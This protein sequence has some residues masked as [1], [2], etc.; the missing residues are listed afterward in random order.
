MKKKNVFLLSAGIAAGIG[1]ALSFVS[2][3]VT[4][5]LVKTALDR[6]DASEENKERSKKKLSKTKKPE[7]YT[8]YR[9]ACA[10]SLFESPLED[11]SIKA[12]DGET[13][14]GH[15]KYVPG[16]KRTVIAVHGWKSSW[17][18][19]FGMISEL[20]DREECNVLYIEQRGQ[21]R[22]GGKHMGFGLLERFDV[23]DWVRY[24]I[25]RED[26]GSLPI[27]LHGISMG[28]STVLMSTGLE[29]PENVKGII[30]DCGFT[31]PQ[32]IWKHVVENNIHF[33]FFGPL[34]NEMCKRRINIGS[35]DYSCPEALRTNKI[36]VLFIHG[37]DDNFV[38]VRMT[39]ENYKA[40]AGEKE[41]LIVPGAGHGMSRFVDEKTYDEKVSLFFRKNDK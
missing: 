14:V 12:S 23:L 19:D 41:L 40:A 2:V 20:W 15:F 33:V 27:Y 7:A 21:N 39:Y 31:S 38:P 4:G 22:S 6:V 35:K 16:A 34:A 8:E 26:V 30:A 11:I 13:L 10:K 1:A 3:Y 5:R 24:I 37:S 17:N 36:P 18:R 28:A 29:L 9:N 25:S 32:E